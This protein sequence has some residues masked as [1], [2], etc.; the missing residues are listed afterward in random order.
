MRGF[1]F[2]DYEIGTPMDIW[3]DNFGQ[4]IDGFSRAKKF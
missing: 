2:V 4:K 1:L 3:P